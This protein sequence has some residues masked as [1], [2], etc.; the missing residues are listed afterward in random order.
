MCVIITRS[1]RLSINKSI[2]CKKKGFKHSLHDLLLLQ[3]H[4]YGVHGFSRLANP[5][6]MAF[7]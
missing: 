2:M 5:L 7:K 1:S 4:L 6:T 3:A